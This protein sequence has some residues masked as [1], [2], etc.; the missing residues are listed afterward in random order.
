MVRNMQSFKYFILLFFFFISI[1]ISSQKAYKIRA[2]TVWVELPGVISNSPSI[3]EG[4]DSLIL[5]YELRKDSTK[6]YFYLLS[7]E[8]EESNN[9][10]IHIALVPRY[11]IENSNILGFFRIKEQP[12]IIQGENIS[13]LFSKTD[14]KESFHI[15][16]EWAEVNQKILRWDTFRIEEFTSWTLSYNNG[17]LSIIE[18][19]FNPLNPSGI[20]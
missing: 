15:R 13:N 11:M 5:R 7:V 19:F 17:K 6:D 18:E 8:N 14:Y 4:I 1:N 10:L 16:R 12:F 9:Y 20:N 2:D 3:I